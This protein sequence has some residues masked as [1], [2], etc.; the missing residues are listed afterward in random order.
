M[1]VLGLRP[2]T[3]HNPPAQAERRRAQSYT[4]KHEMIIIKSSFEVELGRPRA[5]CGDV[6]EGP[7]PCPG[8]HPFVV[9]MGR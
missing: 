2:T 5:A 4:I 8:R 1:V 9:R 6:E 7:W 3:P